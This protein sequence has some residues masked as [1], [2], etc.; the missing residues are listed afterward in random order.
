MSISIMVTVLC[1]VKMRQAF[2]YV[3][4]DQSTVTI[5]ETYGKFDDVLEPRCHYLP[6]VLGQRLASHLSLCAQQLNV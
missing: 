3:Q 6:W 2:C 5:K 4:V 1:R